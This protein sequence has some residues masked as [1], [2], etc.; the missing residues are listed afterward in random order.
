[1]SL[2]HEACSFQ[3]VQGRQPELFSP[4]PGQPGALCQQHVPIKL[5]ILI[6]IICYYYILYYSIAAI[7]T[8]AIELFIF[9]DY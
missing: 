1:M 9:T 2:E 8:A 4:V 7:S 3:R 6:K 5:H